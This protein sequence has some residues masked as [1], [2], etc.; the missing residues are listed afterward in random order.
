M[1]PGIKTTEFWLAVVV[2]I[3][4]AAAT[5]YADDKWAQVAGIV[6]MTL[7]TAGY[8]LS[9]AVAKSVPKE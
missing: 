9:R 2:T 7:S 8:G 6:A 3:A 4:G 5:V 1:K